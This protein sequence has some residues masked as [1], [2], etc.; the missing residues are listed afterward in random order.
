MNAILN[1]LMEKTWSFGM[2][3]FFFLTLRAIFYLKIYADLI[4]QFFKPAHQN[5]RVKFFVLQR[6]MKRQSMDW[7]RIFEK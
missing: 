3:I 2:A 6:R 7:E 5:F 4:P 1:I